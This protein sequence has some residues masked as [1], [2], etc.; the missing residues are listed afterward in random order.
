[1][2]AFWTTP[3]T[4]ATD[5]FADPDMLNTHLRDNIEWLKRPSVVEG[6]ATT[7]VS[8]TSTTATGVP[9]MSGYVFIVGDRL[10]IGFTGVMRADVDTRTLTLQVMVNNA[11]VTTPIFTQIGTNRR[12]AS[13]LVRA[14][15]L[16]SGTRGVAILWTTNAGTM[17]QD[18]STATHRRFFAAE[19]T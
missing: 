5:D 17:Y 18:G 14:A 15:S 3:R 19:Y 11:V 10:L 9:D 8:T 2:T 16:P 12:M 1:M 4:W 6:S 13:F 7:D